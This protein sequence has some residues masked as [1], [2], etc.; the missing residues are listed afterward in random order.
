MTELLDKS[1]PSFFE[2][3]P[4]K[5]PFQSRLIRDI[6]FNIDWKKGVHE[7][8]CSGSVGSS[9]SLVAAHIIVKHCMKYKNA[10]FLIGRQIGRAHV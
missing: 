7:L 1:T 10:R 5:I 2:F 9:K 8:F 4:T 3:D 6:D